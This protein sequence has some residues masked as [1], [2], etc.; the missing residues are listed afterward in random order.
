MNVYQW[1]CVLYICLWRACLFIHISSVQHA[2]QPLLI[3]LTYEHVCVCLE[4]H[5]QAYECEAVW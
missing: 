1:L 3:L 5:A 4:K 2:C